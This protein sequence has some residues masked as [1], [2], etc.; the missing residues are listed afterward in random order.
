MFKLKIAI[1]FKTNLLIHNTNLISLKINIP[2]KVDIP[3]ML[4]TS[5][6]CSLQSLH[7]Y[8]YVKNIKFMMK[9]KYFSSKTLFQN[10]FILRN[11]LLPGTLVSWGSYSHHS[12]FIKRKKTRTKQNSGIYQTLCGGDWYVQFLQQ[13]SL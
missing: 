11:C 5:F 8:L 9:Y 7:I 2:V 4:I 6:Y 3:E 12:S 13:N 1:F 10:A